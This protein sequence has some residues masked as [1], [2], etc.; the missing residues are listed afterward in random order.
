MS[1]SDSYLE[2]Q[3][4]ATPTGDDNQYET[5]Q[6]DQE[7]PQQLVRTE[8]L[9]DGSEDDDLFGDQEMNTNTGSPAHSEDAVGADGGGTNGGGEEPDVTMMELFGSDDDDE[10]MEQSNDG[11]V[12]DDVSSNKFCVQ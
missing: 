2:E 9:D 7:Q 1:E 10:N 4:G 5:A 3:N 11:N 6:M 8:D 12:D